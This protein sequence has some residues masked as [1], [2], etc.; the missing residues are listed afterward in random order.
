MCGF[1]G[2][3]PVEVLMSAI[4]SPLQNLNYRWRWP[5]QCSRRLTPAFQEWLQRVGRAPLSTYL[6]ERD[7][8]N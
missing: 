1:E 6:I 3:V 4:F 5:R 2:I 8:V 7:P